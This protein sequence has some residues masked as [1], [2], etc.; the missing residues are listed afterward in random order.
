M[1]YNLILFHYDTLTV[2]ANVPS[3]PVLFYPF[4]MTC[5]P[6]FSSSFISS[7]FVLS[8]SSVFIVLRVSLLISLYHVHW[9][10]FALVTVILVNDWLLSGSLGELMR[11]TYFDTN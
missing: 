1:N 2:F 6:L 4:C 9:Q 8:I 7:L 3:R 10:P 5:L 11:Q